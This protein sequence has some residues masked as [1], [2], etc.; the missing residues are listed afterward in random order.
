MNASVK[1]TLLVTAGAAATLAG[2]AVVA[3]ADSITVKA[4][5]YVV[6]ASCCAQHDGCRFGFS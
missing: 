5:G 1:N 2:S 6:R 3:S 4:G